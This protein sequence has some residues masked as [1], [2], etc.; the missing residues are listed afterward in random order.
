MK[1]RLGALVALAVLSG[2]LVAT[3]STSAEAA[4]FSARLS[5]NPP[6]VGEVIKV[7][8]VVPPAKRLLQLQT[9][10]GG[11][12]VAVKAARAGA[13][14]AY[15][16]AVRATTSV[17]A[18]RVYAPKAKIKKKKAPARYSNVVRVR[19]LQPSLSLGFAPAPVGIST[20]GHV[21]AENL[22]TPGVATFRP[23][24]PGAAVAIQRYAN[25]KWATVLGGTGRQ[26]TTGAFKFKGVVAGS[27]SDP[28]AFRAVTS[29]GSGVTARYSSVVNPTYWTKNF[30]DNFSDPTRSNLQWKSRPSTGDTNRACMWPYQDMFSVANGVGTLAIQ[31]QNT[32]TSPN[33][34]SCPS[35]FWRTAVVG[36]AQGSPAFTQ[37][38]GMFAAR[39]KF[40]PALGADGA[41]WLQGLGP[42]SAEIDTEYF[43][44]GR[45]DGGLYN[46]VHVVNGS[47]ITSSGGPRPGYR[48]ILGAGNLPSN[49]YH[50]YSVEWTPSGY[51]FRVDGV[52]NF[53]TNKP[54]VASVPEEIM[55]SLV[56]SSYNVGS[57]TK[58]NRTSAAMQVDW[59]RSWTSP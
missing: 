43:G 36:T 28:Y 18:Y 2:V 17:V 9:A 42:Q 7:Q 56:T 24:R 23:A 47:N 53:S 14:G 13:G 32:N 31:R 38:Y 40:Q 3:T 4:P 57:L 54:Q 46:F 10:R 45:Y 44:D 34:D 8:G 27:A 37:Q 16:F 12:W 1:S 58:A 48:S 55:L 41:F 21:L 20:T 49:G 11:R 6:I 19:G 59:V 26:D 30:D 35:G 22:L 5:R 51:T 25:G 52:P 39:I 29:P 33:G 50:V 15:A